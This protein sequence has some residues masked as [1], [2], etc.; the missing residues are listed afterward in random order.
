MSIR[1]AP[2]HPTPDWTLAEVTFFVR[3]GF[4]KVS[5]ALFL[6]TETDTV[7]AA[8]SFSASPFPSSII[9]E[10]SVPQA[11]ATGSIPKMMDACTA[12]WDALTPEVVAEAAY[13]SA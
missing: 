11:W 2:A 6:H 10:P 3:V 4:A 12:S 1:L 7:L 8:T 5:I 13:E 9:A